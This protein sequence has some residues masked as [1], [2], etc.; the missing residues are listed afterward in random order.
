MMYKLYETGAS[1]EKL[2][3]ELLPD[4]SRTIKELLKESAA[5]V[6]ILDLIK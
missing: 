6:A 5:L 3:K 2:L 4:V 1:N